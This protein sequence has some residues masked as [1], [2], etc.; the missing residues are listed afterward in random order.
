[1]WSSPPEDT[2]FLSTAESCFQVLEGGLCFSKVP[3]GILLEGV[4]EGLGEF[5]IVADESSVEVG[6]S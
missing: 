1:M 3:G 2:V 4:G 6:E 5:H